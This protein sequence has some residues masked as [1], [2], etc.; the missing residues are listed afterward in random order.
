I[1]PGSPEWVAPLFV[2]LPTEVTAA[3]VGRAL[4]ELA[5]RHEILRT[6]YAA[7]DGEPYQIVGDH[8][9]IEYEVAEGDL[10]E[11]FAAQLAR[12]FDLER[13][14]VWRA[15]LAKAEGAQVLLVT[16]HH[17]ACDGWSSVRLDA[18]LRALCAG[19]DLPPVELQYADY[20]DWQ[21]RT[22]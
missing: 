18:E 9:E 3:A 13:G 19:E 1:Q 14:P 20:A 7:R 22:L 11:L 4:R 12:G 10:T 16:L 5:R 15:L 17:I 2:R 6:R 21:R 8:V